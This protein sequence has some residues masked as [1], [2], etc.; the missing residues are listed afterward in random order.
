MRAS[1][2]EAF[3]A[4]VER[5]E[6][7]ESGM[8]LDTKALVTTG[9]GYLIDS[10]PAAQALPWRRPE[11][12]DLAS[13]DEVEVD[14]HRV[15]AMRA[16][17]VASRYRTATSL[18]LAEEDIDRLR[19][20]RMAEHWRALVGHFPTLEQAPAD[21]QL[22]MALHA[23]AVGPH[24]YRP[25]YDEHG[26]LMHAGWPKMS[27]AI[28]AGDWATVAEECVL[29]GARPARNEAHQLCFRNAAAVVA[30]CGEDRTCAQCADAL[31]Y[32]EAV[33]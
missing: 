10:V 21:G 29:P 24:A 19:D 14:W 9:V 23:W 4:H 32:P 30:G 11:D 31:H 15:H 12:R 27:A 3:I 1:A 33:V 25:R 17:M 7:R 16:G 26:E 6:G 5:Y 22:G 20:Q 28:D 2:R 18:Y 13:A 8:Y